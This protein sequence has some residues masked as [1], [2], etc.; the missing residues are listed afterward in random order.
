MHVILYHVFRL[1][2]YSFDLR[3]NTAENN[4]KSFTYDWETVYNETNGNVYKIEL[5]LNDSNQPAYKINYELDGGTNASNN[6]DV[7]EKSQGATFSNP[8]KPNHTFLGWYRN[9]N[10]SGSA[11]TSIP[12]GSTG[13]V[14]L[15]AKWQPITRTVTFRPGNHGSGTMDAVAWPYNQYYPLPDC[16]F[17]AEAGYHFTG[18][19]IDN[20]TTQQSPGYQLM[21]DADKTLTAAW[22]LNHYKLHFEPNGGTGTMAD[23]SFVYGTGQQLSYNEF[24]R[25]GYYFSGWNTQADGSGTAYQEG[26]YVNIATQTENETITLYAQWAIH[27]GSFA[28]VGDEYYI[29]NTGGWNVFCDLLESGENLFEGKTVI[30][31]SNIGPI[32]RCAGTSG[33]EFKGTFDGGGK[34]MTLAIDAAGTQAAAPFREIRGATIKNL[35]VTGSV[36]GGIHSGALVGFARGDANVTNTIEKCCIKANVNNPATSG[37]RHIGGVVGHA[38]NSKLVMRQTLFGGTISNTGSFAGGLQ[39]WSDGNT[40]VLE[41]CLFVGS[42]SGNGQFHPIAIH[43]TGTACTD[44]VTNVLYTA[45]PTLTNTNYL[46]AEGEPASVSSSMPEGIGDIVENIS[47][48]RIYSNGF[49]YNNQY[50]RPVVTLHGSGTESDPYR[51]S[52]SEEWKFFCDALQDNDTW[53][54][55]EN[56]YVKLCADIK[57]TR[58]A[59]SSGHEFAGTFD[60]DG[61]TLNIPQRT[62]AEQEYSAPFSRV[63]GATIKNLHIT[64]EI[65]ND[66]YKYTSGLIGEAKGNV[67]VTNCKSSILIFSRLEGDGTHG[68]LIAKI[69][70]GKT[71]ITDCIFDGKL[72]TT[73]THSFGGFVGWNNGTLSINHSLFAPAEISVNQ[74]NCATFARNGGTFNECYYLKQLGEVQGT[75]AYS[76]KPSFACSS[77]TIQDTT[78]FREVDLWLFGS[79]YADIVDGSEEH[80]YLIFCAESWDFFCD[81]IQDNPAWN[82]FSGKYVKLITDISVSRMAGSSNHD[83][84]GTFDGG[85]CTIHF[86]STENVNGVA[87]FSYVSNTKANPDDS[88]D[89]PATIKNLTV[90]CDINTTATHA[91][92]IVGRA[93]GKLNIDCC[94]VYGTITSSNKYAS[95]F[96]GELNNTPANITNSSSVITIIS[97]VNG[98][99]TNGGFVGRTMGGS[100]VNIEGC[101][102]KGKLLTTGS[103][104]CCGGF[105]GWKGGTA[106]ISNSLYFPARLAE[107]ETWV[108]DE[109]SAT[110]SRNGATVSNCYYGQ[111]F[112]EEQGKETHSIVPRGS[113]SIEMVSDDAINYWFSGITAFNP[114]IYFEGARYAG[115]EDEVSLNLYGSDTGYTASAGVLT[116]NKNPYKLLMPDSIVFIEAAQSL[117]GDVNLDGIVNIADATALIDLLLSGAEAPASADVNQDGGVNI[118]DVTALIDYLLSGNN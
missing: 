53:N 89:S 34:T 11:V 96:I 88:E 97:S 94:Y 8:T 60:G 59:G 54:R 40:L 52:K 5:I 95:G 105:I 45:T 22:D 14:T 56:K 85:F 84:C 75:Q 66:D 77:V 79:G 55:F 10:F 73:Y 61:H 15:Y 113:V 112:G 18:W 65:N 118:G 114:G 7:Y 64:G 102:F 38:L 3:V 69:S 36:T 90:E 70:S 31:R 63:D 23:Q 68:G 111:A 104:N 99:A 93:W 106:N 16:G 39:G 83:F 27:S 4:S 80:P 108:S 82:R 115:Y 57:I 32:Q 2:D 58:W 12:S 37:N 103:T 24:M 20:N 100:T 51:I 78:V 109:G 13:D 67:T 9:A 86:T 76:P 42:Y 48:M 30:L 44:T 6:P 43:N 25:P 46:A 17:T 92:G 87:P 98:D 26:Q 29:G 74:T 49:Y 21:M 72:A 110:F 81:C 117:R 41:H 35:T 116:G 33:H 1:P 50:Y 71:T 107:G 91:S 62:S 28:N 19:M 101:I 47:F